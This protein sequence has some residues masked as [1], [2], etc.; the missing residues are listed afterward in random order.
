M[1]GLPQLP[2]LLNVAKPEQVA[3]FGS[4]MLAEQYSGDKIG[5]TSADAL[6]LLKSQ[7]LHQTLLR[8][9]MKQTR[10]WLRDP[11]TRALLEQNLARM[12]GAH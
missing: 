9:L 6:A 3:R 2:A 5:K 8:A 7:G 4:M 11:Q 10:R 1:A 12:G